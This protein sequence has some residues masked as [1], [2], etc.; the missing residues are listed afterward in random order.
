M[1]PETT[2]KW[3]KPEDKKL[4]RMWLA[5]EPPKTTREIADELGRSKSSVYRRIRA[6]DAD[7][8]KGD[9]DLYERITGKSVEPAFKPV[10]VETD[11][12]PTGESLPA[13]FT[14][15]VWGDV[16][17][18]FEDEA[19]LSVLK[20]VARDVSPSLLICIGDVFDFF[21]ISNYRPPKD[22]DPDLQK[23]LDLGTKHLAEMLEIAEPD[24]AIFVG[25]NHEDRWARM[26]QK[27]RE[28]V[29]FRQLLQ[30]PKVRRGLNFETVVGFDDLGYE[31]RP[32]VE[33]ET[34]TLRDN[35][36]VDHGR[37]ANKY[38][39]KKHLNEFGMNVLFGHTHKFQTFSRRTVRGQEAG[40]SIGCLCD[41][42]PF[43]DDTVASWQNGF[44]VVTFSEDY[45]NVEQVRIHD[46]TAIFR[47][48]RYDA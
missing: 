25:G 20:Q 34:L 32:H 9:R 7:G 46:G 42:N 44:A 14:A 47:G 30:I 1:T 12:A 38:A 10:R 24:R 21:E 48:E 43:Y 36:I 4:L 17:F 39:A 19:A 35:L 28:D 26:L 31:Y 33:G 16:H 2:L 29:R 13:D 23:A 45:F 6:Y 15:L 11:A 8:H 41:L 27:T 37:Y 22:K 5:E 18:P 3:S 40:F